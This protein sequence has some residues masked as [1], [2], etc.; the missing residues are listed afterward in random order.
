MKPKYR[1]SETRCP[2][3][4]STLV[5]TFQH[6]SSRAEDSTIIAIGTIIPNI[7]N[8]LNRYLQTVQAEA[9]SQPKD[10]KRSPTLM[11]SHHKNNARN[12][13]QTKNIV[14]RVHKNPSDEAAYTLTYHICITVPPIQEE[15]SQKIQHHAANRVPRKIQLQ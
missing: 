8:V 7:C 15:V 1:Q 5:T 2:T 6:L 10:P 11:F 3:R 12:K 14:L 13:M 4:R 9:Y